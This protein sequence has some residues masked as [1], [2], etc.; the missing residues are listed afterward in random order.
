[1]E[2]RLDAIVSITLKSTQ[3]KRSL[4]TL[5]RIGCRNYAAHIE[6]YACGHLL[7]IYMQDYALRPLSCSK[8]LRLAATFL[9]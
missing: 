5:W 9:T 3:V 2:L 4:V 1:M 7:I 6:D 8:G